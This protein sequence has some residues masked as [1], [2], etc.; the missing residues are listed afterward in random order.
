MCMRPD[1]NIYNLTVL[2]KEESQKKNCKCKLAIKRR[3]H[4]I[5]N[6][7]GDNKMAKVM[8]N[9]THRGGILR[10]LNGW[11]DIITLALEAIF[12]CFADYNA[13]QSVVPVQQL[14]QFIDLSL[15][16]H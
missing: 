11:L 4:A 14:M 10:H 12:L 6:I 15:M 5:S 16:E 7:R 1:L 3:L 2:S 8:I 13:D 9:R